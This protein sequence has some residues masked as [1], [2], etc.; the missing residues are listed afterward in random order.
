M[1]VYSKKYIA[2]VLGVLVSIAALIFGASQLLIS[3]DEPDL[4]SVSYGAPSV[5]VGP[6]GPPSVGAPTFPPPSN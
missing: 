4:E 2:W 3:H 1:A 5:G 6:S